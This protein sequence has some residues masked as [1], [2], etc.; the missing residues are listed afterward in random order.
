MGVGR[1]ESREDRE[2]LEG[3]YEKIFKIYYILLAALVST[4]TRAPSWG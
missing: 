1:E 4:T 2:L 3:G